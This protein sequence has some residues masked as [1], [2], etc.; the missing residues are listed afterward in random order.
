M[1]GEVNLQRR[2]GHIAVFHCMEVRAR[3]RVLPFTSR[4]NPVDG[5]PTSVLAGDDFFGTMPEPETRGLKAAQLLVRQV[6]HIH[7]ENGGLRQGMVGLPL[8]EFARH[9]GGGGKVF[10]RCI[11]G[12]VLVRHGQRQGHGGQAE[13]AAFHGSRDRAAVQDIVAEI[14]AIINARHHTVEGVFEQAGDGKQDTVRW[15]TVDEMPTGPGIM[16]PQRHFQREGVAGATAVSLGSHHGEFA[17]TGQAV[18]KG[19]QAGSAVAVI[20]RQ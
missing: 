14:C 13:E 5:P 7:I 10:L 11:G 12:I 19:L 2:H 1:A 16:D 18:R 9:A 6:R 15:G 20:V 4:A 17:K 3:A 8:D